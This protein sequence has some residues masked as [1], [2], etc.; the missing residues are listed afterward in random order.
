[1]PNSSSLLPLNVIF[2][3]DKEENL[4]VTKQFISGVLSLKK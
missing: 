4:K 3:L 1:M 2:D